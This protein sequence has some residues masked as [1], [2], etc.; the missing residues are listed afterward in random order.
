LARRESMSIGKITL[1]DVAERT[2]LSIATVSRALRNETGV[3]EE[4]RKRIIE[5]AQEMGASVPALGKNG[6]LGQVIVLVLDSGWGAFFD[7][8]LQELARR[9]NEC[10]H[11]VVVHRAPRYESVDEGLARVKGMTQG[12]VVLGTWDALTDA[13]ADLI[14]NLPVPVVLINRYLSRHASSVTLDDYG[15]GFRAVRHLVDLGH[16]RIACMPG[17]QSSPAMRHWLRGFRTGLEDRGLF[18]PEL[19]TEPLGGNILEWACRCVRALL[20]L[21][22]PPTA[23][24]ACND[25]AAGAVIVSMETQGIRVPEQMSVMGHDNLPQA[26]DVGLTTFDYRLTEMGYHTAYL[27]EGLL[28]G[29][30]SSPVHISLTPELID[31]RTTA[32]ARGDSPTDAVS[33][34]LLSD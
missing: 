18:V 13:D 9:A 26:H 10:D 25:I 7:E 19:V 5:V 6:Q 12:V 31:R 1:K 21:P 17:V 2:N 8:A 33:T 30:F 29:E 20:D 3:A 23:I 11:E 15:T 16:R 4:T 24:W 34:R 27:V 32:L 14:A 28:Q 22:Q